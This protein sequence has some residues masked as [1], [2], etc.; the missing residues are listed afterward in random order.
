MHNNAFSSEQVHL[1]LSLTSKSAT[2][3][4]R[5]V[6]E[7]F[8]LVMCADFSPDSDQ[9]TFKLQEAL[10]WTCIL[11]KN[12]LMMD[13]FQPLSSPDVNS[14]YLSDSHSDGTHSL[15]SIHC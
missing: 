2:C 12:I 10:L 13:V 8:Q 14:W 15:Q 11:V 3:L 5:T 9:N 1:R 4:F 6:L 7:L